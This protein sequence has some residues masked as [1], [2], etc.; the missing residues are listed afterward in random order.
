[1]LWRAYRNGL[2]YIDKFLQPIMQLGNSYVANSTHF[3]NILQ[4]TKV[5]NDGLLVT[6]DVSSLYTNISHEG[7]LEAVSQVLEMYDLL[8]LPPMDVSRNFSFFYVKIMFLA[9]MA[10]CTGNC[11]E[12]TWARN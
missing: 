11:M 7:A 2:A 12:W 3:I 1:M 4:S 8:H 5:P 6:L 9:L 10:R